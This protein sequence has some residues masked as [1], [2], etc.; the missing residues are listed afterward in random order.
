MC[1]GGERSLLHWNDRSLIRFT[2]P[3]GD[4]YGEV[5]FIQTLLVQTLWQG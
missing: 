3:R 5:E 4:G 2:S 1:D